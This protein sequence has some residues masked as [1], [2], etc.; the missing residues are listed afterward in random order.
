MASYWTAFAS[1]DTLLASQ[2][3]GVVDNF[4]DIAI[5]WEQ[6][7]AGTEGGAFTSGAWTKRTLNT[8]NINNITGCSIAASVVTL[9]TAGTYY[10]KAMAPAFQVNGNQLVIQNT[11]AGT[12][13]LIGGAQY[14]GS[15]DIQSYPAFVEGVITIAGST[16]FELQHRCTQTKAGNGL[17]AAQNITTEKYAVLYISRIA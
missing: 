13:A 4:S 7:S 2:L 12:Q 16:N 15:G 1:G 10:F 8:T 9:S 11:T 17:G 5:F 6:Q 14:N 3:N